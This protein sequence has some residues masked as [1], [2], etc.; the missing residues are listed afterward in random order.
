MVVVESD[1]KDIVPA[2]FVSP[3][4]VR[5]TSEIVACEVA[6]R[7]SFH[8]VYFDVISC[9]PQDLEDFAYGVAFSLGA[10]GCA[11]DVDSCEII[12][13]GKGI[14]IDIR[15][16]KGCC[17]PAEAL[18]RCPVSGLQR[19]QRDV[20]LHPLQEGCEVQPVELSGVFGA[21]AIWRAS[22]T[23]LSLQGMHRATGATHA[24]VFVD[25]TGTYRYLREDIGRHCAV[26]KLIGALVRDGVDPREGFVYLSSRCALDLVVKCARYGIGLVATVSAPTTAVLQFAQQAN[27]TLCAFARGDHFT[28]YTH[29]ERLRGVLAS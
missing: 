12:A 25:K 26:D 23:L 16:R 18:K 27:V 7:I 3:D 9:T 19:Q 14:D 24:A 2:Y 8:D 20:V 6:V 10:I 13:T 5:A 1:Y 17:V 28:V 29:P 11:A 15:L 22:S 21:E 4:G